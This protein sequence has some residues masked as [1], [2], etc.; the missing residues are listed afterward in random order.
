MWRKYPDAKLLG[1]LALLNKHLRVTCDT[2]DLHQFVTLP[3]FL[4]R[5]LHV[6]LFNQA[7]CNRHHYQCPFIT[8]VSA[9]TQ[10]LSSCIVN[11][12]FIF[13]HRLLLQ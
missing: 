10:G 9:D 3:D 4:I 11:D 12:N 5:V 7:R 2:V 13:P 1:L 6:P 8:S